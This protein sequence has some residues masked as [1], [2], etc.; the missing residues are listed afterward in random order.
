MASGDGGVQ[1]AARPVLVYYH[2]L[3][4][5]DDAETPNAF[6]LLPMGGGVKLQDIRAKFPLPGQYHFRFKM[7]LS[8][9]SPLLWMDMTNED[10]QVPL[11]D[12][13]IVAKVTRI[14]WERR[15]ETTPAQAVPASAVNR[16]PAPSPTRAAPVDTRGR[17]PQQQQQQQQQ[18]NYRPQ[19]VHHAATAPTMPT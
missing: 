4:D 8:E 2:I 6:P 18:Q 14:S 19:K 11:L 7:R 9:A 12:G 3:E 10:S 15:V 17:A 1:Q 5:K 13:K 16:V